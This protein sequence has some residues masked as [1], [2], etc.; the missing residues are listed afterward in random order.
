MIARST[1]TR[2]VGLLALGSLTL[3]PV[4]FVNQD[5]GDPS[6]SW[7][8]AEA[9]EVITQA[10]TVG[11]SYLTY[12]EFIDQLHTMRDT[13]PDNWVRTLTVT[14]F[15]RSQVSNFGLPGINLVTDMPQLLDR[16]E[17]GEPA[18]CNDMATLDEFAL[19]EA[20]LQA[21]RYHLAANRSRIDTHV[22]VDVWLPR[23]KAWVMVDPTFGGYYTLNGIPVGTPEIHSLL[24]SGSQGELQFQSLGNWMTERPQDYYIDPR[25]LYGLIEMQNPITPFQK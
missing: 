14:T 23:R 24:T 25:L 18:L 22:T 19:N 11:S 21:H 5:E 12:Q 2:M 13:I 16:V 6:L 4:H 1:I 9:K 15:V 7:D 10:Q 20:G 8:L 3:F 17:K